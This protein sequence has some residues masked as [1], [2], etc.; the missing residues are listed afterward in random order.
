VLLILLKMSDHDPFSDWSRLINRPVYAADG[1]KVGFL[2]SILADYL[3]VK[4]GFVVL[5]KYY[6]PK[7]LAE[8]VDRKG[9]IRLRIT[10][11]EV[12]ANY[13]YSKMKDVLTAIGYLPER[14]V[15]PS[16]SYDRLQTLRYSATRNRLAACIAFVSG[17]LFLASGYK[18]NIEI[19]NLVAAEF[20]SIQ[21]LR[22]FWNLVIV[23]IGF[24]AILSQLG[25]ITVM[26][27]AGFFAANR[28]NFGKLLVMVGTGQG[29]F[30]IAIRILVELW[31][32]QFWSVNNYVTW[33]TS[34][35]TGL[36]ILF[37]VVSPTIAKGKGDSILTKTIRL[38]LRRK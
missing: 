20:L 8:S 22:Q 4:K 7:T 37:A 23:P 27:G 9:R 21:S 29:L 18:A 38:V 14:N 1:K 19:Y 3:L 11:L 36:G 2:R 31:S 17:I 33:L 32:G 16:S 26:M 34:T 30:T 15:L 25:G 13:T 5:N 6:I 12:R 10:T 28:V 24:L 35:A